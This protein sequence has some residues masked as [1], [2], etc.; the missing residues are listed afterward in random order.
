MFVTTGPIDFFFDKFGIAYIKTSFMTWFSINGG[1]GIATTI[2]KGSCYLK[3]THPQECP[4]VTT[5]SRILAISIYA[6]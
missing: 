3:H 1:L 4:Y 2:Y 5:I 6:C